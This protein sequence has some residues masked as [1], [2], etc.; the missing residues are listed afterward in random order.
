MLLLFNL[1]L[2]KCED[3]YAVD[4]VVFFLDFVV[5]FLDFGSVSFNIFT[6]KD[7]VALDEK[8]GEAIGFI[9]VQIVEFSGMKE[10]IEDLEKLKN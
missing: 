9:A 7:I 5:F 3:F 4:F 1:F 2:M 6:N 10:D 8:S